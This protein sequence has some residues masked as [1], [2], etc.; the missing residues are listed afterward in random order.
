MKEFLRSKDFGIYLCTYDFYLRTVT[1]ATAQEWSLFK[2]LTPEIFSASLVNIKDAIKKF[3]YNA[4]LLNLNSETTEEGGVATSV[5][6]KGIQ[7]PELLGDVE[8]YLSCLQLAKN[9]TSEMELNTKLRL[10]VGIKIAIYTYKY[11]FIMPN[12]ERNQ[13]VDGFGASSVEFL[14]TVSWEYFYR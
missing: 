9:K 14:Q 13:Y 3:V 11:I 6:M 7:H 10:V 8:E 1:N 2:S 12:Y 5:N 4:Y